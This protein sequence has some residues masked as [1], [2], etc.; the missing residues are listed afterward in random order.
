MGM[1]GPV[2]PFSETEKCMA[3][4]PVPPEAV[5]RMAAGS[6]YCPPEKGSAH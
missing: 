4:V 6:L 2:V 3:S 5:Q 1:N